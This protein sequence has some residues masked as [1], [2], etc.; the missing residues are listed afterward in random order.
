LVFLAGMLAAAVGLAVAELMAGLSSLVP[1]PVATVGDVFIDGSP[2]DVVDVA[3]RSVGSAD[4]PLL[5]TAIVIVTLL[6]GG[7]LATASLKRWW[8]GPLG[9]GAWTLFAAWAGA[10]DPLTA[11]GAPVAAS[12]VAGIVALGA[13]VMLVRLAARADGRSWPPGWPE[14]TRRSDARADRDPMTAGAGDRRAFLLVAGLTAAGAAVAGL[15]GRRLGERFSVESARAELAL[16]P[17]GTSSTPG[18]GLDV[19]GISS[20]ITPNDEF[21][22]IDNALIVPQVSPDDFRLSI[23]GLVDQPLELTYDD[24]LAM[25]QV[26]ETVTIACVSNEVGDDLVGN[27]EWQGVLLSDLLDRAGLQPGAEQVVGRSVDRFTAGF[28]VEAATDGRPAMV[29]IG[30]NGEPLP[31]IH[32]FPARLIVPGFYGYVSATKWLREILI[33]TWDGFDGY[34]I[35][36]G[37]SK[38]GPIK[39]QSRVDVPMGTVPAGTVSIAG[40]AWAPTRGISGVE[41]QIDDGDWQEAELGPGTTD[42]TWRQWVLRTDLDSGSY[43]V[44]VRATDGDGETQTEDSAP[45]RPDGA[46][47]WHAKTIQVS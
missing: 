28:P 27:A 35:P 36:L 18:V 23:T 39:T 9:I 16:P 40:V 10:R 8:I 5:L 31:I 45:P 24:L 43:T 47:G 21:Y 6:V 32:G 34:W 22:R 19:P 13:F 14:S 20:F 44:R 7:R 2:G 30:M 17:V 37:W 33:T 11:A 29:A 38:E 41:V 12:L 3:I 42:L 25:P 4:K 46:T 26:S 1:S 15:G